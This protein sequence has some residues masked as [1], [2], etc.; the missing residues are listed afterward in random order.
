MSCVWGFD[1]DFGFN[2][3]DVYVW[4]LCCKIGVEWFEMVWGMGY[5]LIGVLN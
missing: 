5:W 1:F 4:Y 2:V 3:V